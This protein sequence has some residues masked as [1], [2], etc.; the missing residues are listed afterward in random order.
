[1][2]AERSRFS[3]RRQSAATVVRQFPPLPPAF[4]LPLPSPS[5]A[6][7]LLCG[8]WPSSRH[9][10]HQG[11]LTFRPLLSSGS[12]RPRL[13]LSRKL[14]LKRMRHSRK[15]AWH[16]TRPPEGSLTA[17]QCCADVF[18]WRIQPRPFDALLSR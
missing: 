13:P 12:W 17:P 4:S 1:T 2:T 9:L 14:A 15:D 18:M 7:S 11:G 8:F 6:Y 5:S 3:P 10:A 16:L